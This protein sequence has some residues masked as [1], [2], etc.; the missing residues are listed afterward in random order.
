MESIKSGDVWPAAAT[1]VLSPMP[2][3]SEG[4]SKIAMGDGR[5]EP[6]P[7]LANWLVRRRQKRSSMLKK[8]NWRVFLEPGPGKTT[9][10]GSNWC[11]LGLPFPGLGK[12]T[13]WICATLPFTFWGWRKLAFWICALQCGSAPLRLG[14]AFSPLRFNLSSVF[15]CLKKCSWRNDTQECRSTL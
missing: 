14:L 7:W 5:S 1:A 4:L 15:L 10:N 11:S 2:C 3:K 12:W 8:S 9:S 13:F 6:S